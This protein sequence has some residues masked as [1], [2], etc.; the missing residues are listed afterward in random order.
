MK[1]T[2]QKRMK[3]KK[4]KKAPMRKPVIY[5]TITKKI[6]GKAPEK[7]S[8]HLHDGRKLRSVYELIDE[9]ET[10]SEE[11]FRH[12][13]TDT[14]NHFAN[15]IEGVFKE[16]QLADELRHIKNRIDTQRALLKHLVRELTKAH[17]GKRKN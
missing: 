7:Y 12:F 3:T 8:F 13:V 6:L 16:K 5:V 2:K 4:M 15:W 1:R 17:A 9:L 14:E 11:T 10:M